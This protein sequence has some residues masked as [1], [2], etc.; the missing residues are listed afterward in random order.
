MCEVCRRASDLTN[1]SCHDL[2]PG[3]VP[4]ALMEGPLLSLLPG[5]N[6]EYSSLDHI[7]QLTKLPAKI[8][9]DR[10]NTVTT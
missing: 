2:A 6:T 7:S 4:W 1:A 9:L 3:R 10:R 8:L 5:H